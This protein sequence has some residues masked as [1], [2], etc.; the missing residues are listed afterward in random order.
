VLPTL[1]RPV[2]GV[3]LAELRDQGRL[4]R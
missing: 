2:G 3:A 1:A 4:E